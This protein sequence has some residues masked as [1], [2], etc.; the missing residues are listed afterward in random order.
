MCLEACMVM[1]LVSCFP[2][3]FFLGRKKGR[4]N[5]VKNIFATKTDAMQGGVLFI[6]GLFYLFTCTNSFLK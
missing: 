1:L 2:F 6:H 5:V 3:T 4:G